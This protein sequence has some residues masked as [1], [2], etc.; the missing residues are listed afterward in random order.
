MTS[1]PSD[2]H[3]HLLIP[4]SASGDD[5]PQQAVQLAERLLR[6]ARQAQT[7]AEQEQAARLARMMADPAGKEL[8]IALVDQA[9]RSHHPDR[10][11]DQLRHLLHVYGTPHYMD[12]WERVALV[13]GSAMSHY[14]PNLVVP[15]VIARLRQET[16]AVILP[17]E[18][19]DLRRYLQQRRQDGTRLNLNQLGEAILGEGEA[20]RR[21]QAYLDLLARDDVEYISVKVSS[22]FSQLNLVAFD[23]TRERVKARLRLLYRQ[24][25]THHYAHP[26][27]RVTPKFVNLDMEAYTDLY[28]T[29]AAFTEVLDEPEFLAL[30]AGIVLQAYLPEAFSIQQDLTTWAI[31]RCARGGAP[32]KLRLVKGANLAMEQVEAA[33]HGW[34]QAPYTTKLE[35]DANFKRLVAYGCQPE[36]A[37]AV[38]LGVAS[39]NLFDVAYGLL[40]RQQY[41]VEN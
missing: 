39:H 4:C 7:S 5:L 8:T 13:L 23:A 24:A 18:E 27:G 28:L 10:I 38:R 9:F 31:A 6:T 21:M 40:L 33:L 19:G 2:R 37:R 41:G 34:S 16:R 35:T 36:H 3:K 15:P 1:Q 26:N 20:Q 11:A 14:L 29:V 25:M 22:V 12:W 17:G 32:I 30:R